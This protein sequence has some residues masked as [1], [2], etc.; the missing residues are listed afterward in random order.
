[1]NKITIGYRDFA[2]IE[3]LIE[4]IIIQLDQ[5]LLHQ[6]NANGWTTDK[7]N[8]RLAP[9]AGGSNGPLSGGVKWSGV[10]EDDGKNNIRAA[11]RGGDIDRIRQR[12][13]R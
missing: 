9:A 13:V 3:T 10:G 5:H 6:C 2:K 1:M 4:G 8:A 12:Q 11:S 7:F